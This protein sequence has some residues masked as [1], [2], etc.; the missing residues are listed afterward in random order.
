MKYFEECEHVKSVYCL[1]VCR[2]CEKEVKPG[3]VIYESPSGQS[4]LC[5]ECGEQEV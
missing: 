3:D 2:E 4:H 1:P 5:Q